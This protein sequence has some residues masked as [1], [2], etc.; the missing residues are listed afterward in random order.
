MKQLFMGW[1]VLRFVSSDSKPDAHVSRSNS[2]ASYSLS[3]FK[4]K[5]SQMPPEILA[6]SRLKERIIFVVDRNNVYAAITIK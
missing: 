4:E 6:K 1:S 3:F 5:I 2:R